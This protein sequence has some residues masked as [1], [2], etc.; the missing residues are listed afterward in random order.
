MENVKINVQTEKLKEVIYR[1]PK[2]DRETSSKQMTGYA[3]IDQ[4]WL[5]YYTKEKV[6]T[7]NKTIY[8]ALID[9]NSDNLDATAFV[10][11]DRE[12]IEKTY[13]EFIEDI[14]KMANSLNA[15]GLKPGDEIVGS[16]KNS[17]ESIV[18]VFAKSKLGL[19]AHL[20]DSTN[21][22]SE[23]ARM[24]E[25]TNAKYCFIPED[26]IDTAAIMAKSNQVE[27]VI[28][29]PSMYSDKVMTDIN[30]LENKK[31]YETYDDF[32]SNGKETNY[33]HNLNKDEV[34]SVV[35]TGGSTGPSKGVMLTDFGLVSKYYMQINSNWK[36]GRQRTSLCC[37]PTVIAFGLS[38]GTISPLLAGEKCVLIDCFMGLQNAAE[39]ILK[40]KPNDWSCSPIHVERLV[41]SP[42]IQEDTDLSHLEMLPCGGDGM[43][44]TSDE[45]ARQFFEEH[46]AKDCFAQGCGFSESWGAFCYGL[47]EENQAG[48]MGIPLY[49]NISGVFDPETGEE[50]QYNQVGEWAVLTDSVMK[51]YFGSAQDKDKKALKQHE[52]G[53][54]WLHPG[55]MVRMNENGQIAMQDRTSRTF[56]FMGFKIYPSALEAF[57]STHPAIKKCI[58]SGIESPLMP[59][60]AITEQKVP[61]ANVSLNEDYK[62]KESE[63]MEDLEEILKENAQSYVNVFA[64]IFRDELP[65]T[66]RGKINYQQL[67][68]EGYSEGEN[69]L[70][71]VKTPAL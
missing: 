71:Y 45:K 68:Q 14:D 37:L 63:V 27:K 25:E 47:G 54:I 8:Q 60:L 7:P 67:E 59:E 62:G 46:G 35:Y 10:L 17:Y 41:N 29:F 34:S 38:D 1:S 12:D 57:L 24:L 52:D 55:D 22:P 4:P 3:T 43:T 39:N 2:I 49:G 5:K 26:L 23:K 33:V 53:S 30:T 66:N 58:I 42:L 70:V 31:K 32:M 48:Y 19:K 11:G 16:F 15:L 40:Y 50:L 21:S 56:N 13:G 6:E 61:I 18:L 51:G 44:K 36:W 28:V 20:I 9:N 64:Y 65:Y 69:K